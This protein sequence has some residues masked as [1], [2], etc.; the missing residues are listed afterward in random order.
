MGDSD[1]LKR[2]P[3]EARQRQWCPE[4]KKYVIAVRPKTNL[5]M[6]LLLSVLTMGLWLIVWACT[7]DLG[8][9]RPHQCPSCGTGTQQTAASD[10]VDEPDSPHKE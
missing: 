9:R 7:A 4:C 5:V 3:G 6:N 2:K 8:T 1:G 10:A